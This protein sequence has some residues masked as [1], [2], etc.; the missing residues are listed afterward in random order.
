MQLVFIHGPAACG[1]LTVASEF[2]A[3]SGMRLFHNH[4]TVDLVAALFD[5]GSEPFVRLRESIWLDAIREAS[6][7]GQSLVFTFNPEVTVQPAFPDRVSATVRASGGEVVFVELTCSE[8]EIERR[9]E[10]ESR[11]KF[12]KL[13]SLPRY[14]E[15]R[16]AGAFVY[17]ALPE[18]ALVLDTG[19]LDPRDAAAQILAH[20]NRSAA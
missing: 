4:L 9:I 17:P 2:A 7:Q 18:A 3:L 10:N 11:A 19:S 5:F 6:E 15:L 8:A 20:L 1:K 16:D 14:R 12:G 13:R